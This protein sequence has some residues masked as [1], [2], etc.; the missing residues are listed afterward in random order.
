[1]TPRNKNI[2]LV[3]GFLV[4]LLIAYN[5]SF[6]K[7]FSLKRQIE[8]LKEQSINSGNI[9]SLNAQL[10]IRNRYADSILNH[11]NVSSS[12]VHN[13]LLEFLN[14][15]TD[16]GSLKIL[17][18]DP[19]HIIVADQ[20]KLVFFRFIMEGPY[21]EAEKLLFDLEQAHFYGETYHVNFKKKRVYRI[22]KN[23]LE[24]TV[25][26]RNFEN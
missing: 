3:L 24:C 22:R 14:V 7:T 9:S 10:M 25:I 2:L 17:E 13:S 11:H 6:S 4:C 15:R 19:A 16:D 8:Q 26:L 20:E 5:Y 12:S 1:M 23:I 18:F 21:V